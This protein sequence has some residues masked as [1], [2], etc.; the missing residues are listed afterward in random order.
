MRSPYPPLRGSHY[1]GAIKVIGNFLNTGQRAA[2]A[3]GG[4]LATCDAGCS[5]PE[6]LAHIS[7]TCH[8]T[9][10]ARTQRHNHV[11]DLTKKFLTDKGMTCLK[12]PAIPTPEGLRKPDLIAT[13]NG[14]TVILDAQVVADNANLDEADKRKITYYNRPAIRQ[15]VTN[16]IGTQDTNIK[17][18]S[19]TLNWR[20]AWSRNSVDIL[21]HLGLNLNHLTMISI[22]ALEGTHRIWKIFKRSTKS[23]PTRWA[24]RM[25]GRPP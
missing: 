22:R 12:E 16:T 19:I 17:L 1:I 24:G 21:K 8:R 7:Q 23:R 14:Q 10:D 4:R 3:T 25:P 13:K 11:L 9:A 5:R 6:T 15:Y 2:R 20:G 18:G